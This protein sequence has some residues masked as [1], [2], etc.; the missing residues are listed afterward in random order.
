MLSGA[1]EREDWSALIRA[2]EEEARGALTLD[3]IRTLAEAGENEVFARASAMPALRFDD[4]CRLYA[5]QLGSADPE[6][7]AHIFLHAMQAGGLG[8]CRLGDADTTTL[9]CKFIEYPGQADPPRVPFIPLYQARDVGAMLL[10]SEPH[11][12]DWLGRTSHLI[13]A[14][15][16]A[17]AFARAMEWSLPRWWAGELTR[18]HETA[19]GRDEPDVSVWWDAL[20]ADDELYDPEFGRETEADKAERRA[21]VEAEP[22]WTIP[23]AIAWTYLR[24]LQIVADLAT[25]PHGDLSLSAE[26]LAAQREITARQNGLIGA[27]LF[28]NWVLAR[29][30]LLRALRSGGVTA[31]GNLDGQTH[32]V[33]AEDW[34]ILELADSRRE[35]I[36]TV[37]QPFSVTRIKTVRLKRHDLFKEFPPMEPN[38]KE[39]LRQMFREKRFAIRDDYLAVLAQA[40][41][42]LNKTEIRAVWDAVVRERD[43]QQFRTPGRKKRQPEIPVQ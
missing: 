34:A 28:A 13:V 16:T 14:R 33:T 31:V 36:A 35:W 18:T 1:S 29:S 24:D 9:G 5:H 23:Q 12:R 25:N 27:P 43:F 30:A 19:S 11:A 8:H 6:Q 22:W 15:S 39:R 3:G 20:S 40:H 21:A 41:P 32:R 42:S 17:G 7:I 2:A 26:L 10:F 37:G 4:F 38:A